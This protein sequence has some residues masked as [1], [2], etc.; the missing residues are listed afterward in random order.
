MIVAGLAL[1]AVGLFAYGAWR[2]WARQG[3]IDMAVRAAEY[4]LFRDRIYPNASLEPPPSSDATLYTVYPPYAFPLFAFFFE[5]GGLVQGRFVIE[6]LSLASLVV[7][8]MFAYRTL[9]SHGPL[10]AW[11]GAL[12]GAAIAG[13]GT[14]LSVGQ[15][16]I[17]CVGL[18]VQQMIFLERGK[19]LAAGVCWALAMIKPQIALPFAVLFPMRRQMAGGFLGAALLGALTVAACEWTGVSLGRMIEFWGRGMSLRFLE[20]G[21]VVGPGG[22]AKTLGIDH[23]TIQ[24]IAIGVMGALLVPVAILMRRTRDAAM[25]PVAAL[26]AVCGM[27]CFY[28]RHYDNIMLFPTV[29]AALHTAAAKPSRT[30]VAVATAMLV[31]VLIPKRL[32]HDVPLHEAALA[33]TWVTAAVVPFATAAITR[34]RSG[35]KD[36][37]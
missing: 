27:L 25:L 20:H 6:A 34:N 9:I 1:Q 7:M 36:E 30:T 16:S 8:G 37:H 29:L 18:I 33:I 21:V 14:A 11:V 13:N 5:P 23:R 12:S 22:I 17:L 4:A 31:S 2:A 3:D 15:F 28:H 35:D 26:C 19:P 10:L 24:I 32:L